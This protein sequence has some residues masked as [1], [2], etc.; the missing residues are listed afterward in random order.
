L[1]LVCVSGSVSNH[2]FYRPAG[3]PSGAP[4]LARGARIG[5]MELPIREW[6]RGHEK[7]VWWEFAESCE[8]KNGRLAFFGHEMVVRLLKRI[9]HLAAANLVLVQ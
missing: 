2:F 6:S 7:F 1:G 3:L 5:K 9:A 8:T 4:K